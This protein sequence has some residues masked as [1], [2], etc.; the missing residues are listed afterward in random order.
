MESVSI[1][2]RD[3]PRTVGHGADKIELLSRTPD[4]K[5]QFRRN[6][7]VIVWTIGALL[8]FL[9]MLVMLNFT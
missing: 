9:T 4:E 2:V 6:K 7:N 3:E 1:K 8:I 5:S